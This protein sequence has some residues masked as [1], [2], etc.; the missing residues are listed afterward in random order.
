MQ[1]SEIINH[2]AI[3][4]NARV[5]IY[6]ANRKLNAYEALTVSNRLQDFLQNWKAHGK[7]LNAYGEVLHDLFVV[8]VAD[9]SGQTATGCSIDASVDFVRQLGHE[10]DV[11]FFDRFAIAWEKDGEMH[12]NTRADFEKLLAEGQINENTIVY[13][14]LIQDFGSFRQSWRVPF[15][16]SWHVRVFSL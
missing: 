7:S 2:P 1:Q 3:P 14:N 4:E 8:L 9:E 5:W 16:Q 12:V 6:Q 15:S 11:D 10:L 13:N